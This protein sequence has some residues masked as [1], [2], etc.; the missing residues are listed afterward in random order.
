ML[1]TFM[2]WK[3][4]HG[5]ASDNLRFLIDHCDYIN[6]T[7]EEVDRDLRIKT[8]FRDIYDAIIY[9]K[10]FSSPSKPPQRKE[11]LADLSER[12]RLRRAAALC[13]FNANQHFK[14]IYH[15]PVEFMCTFWAYYKYYLF[16]C[17]PTPNNWRQCFRWQRPRPVQFTHR[18]C[19]FLDSIYWP[20][21]RSRLLKKGSH[22]DGE[23]LVWSITP[24]V[25]IKPL[26]QPL[27][28]LISVKKDLSDIALDPALESFFDDINNFT[29]SPTFS[30]SNPEFVDLMYLASSP[31]NE[32]LDESLP[33]LDTY[34]DSESYSCEN[35]NPNNFLYSLDDRERTKPPTQIDHFNRA[36]IW[37]EHLPESPRPYDFATELPVKDFLLPQTDNS[38][39]D[40][41]FNLAPS[42]SNGCTVDQYD[43]DMAFLAYFEGRSQLV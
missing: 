34:E 31:L 25:K 12:E 32:T 1:E 17:F 36:S 23:K 35:P 14:H 28:H 21:M 40:L 42:T 22:N 2:S 29:L 9:G 37:D 20:A 4:R 6:L 3:I 19:M 5:Y 16:L 26:V 30:L 7:L 27:S 38:V 15:S 33:V 13:S 24:H 11:L 8:L 39:N 10:D 41:G 43:T 18:H